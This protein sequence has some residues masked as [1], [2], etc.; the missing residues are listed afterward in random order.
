MVP[1]E[2]KTE[3]GESTLK[4]ESD[5][6]FGKATQWFAER[7][8]RNVKK[9][10][11]RH[12]NVVEQAFKDD[13]F[14]QIT[15][16]IRE[17]NGTGGDEL[18]IDQKESP[19]IV[20]LMNG[21]VNPQDI[22]QV[23]PFLEKWGMA[24]LRLASKTRGRVIEVVDDTV[25]GDSISGYLINTVRNIKNDLFN[26]EP[27]DVIIVFNASKH[28]LNEVIKNGGENTALVV[29]GHG[30]L[31]S[32][33]MTDGKV[34][35][36]DVETPKIP[37]KAFIQHTCAAPDDSTEEMGDRWAQQ[38][39]GWRRGT[40]PTDFIDYPLEPRKLTSKKQ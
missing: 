27:C 7:A 10:Q 3:V 12:L 5:Q 22:V 19:R 20:L 14:V 24:G 23:S 2:F 30:T 34:M 25:R 36:T 40:S 1:K 21:L 26:G 15:S 29:G 4:L 28:D 31:G 38:S 37:L 8:R 16:I 35:N 9:H 6:R 13:P 17:A 11:T 33:S 32:L 39:Y 18:L